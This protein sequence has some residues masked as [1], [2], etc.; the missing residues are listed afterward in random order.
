[1]SIKLRFSIVKMKYPKNRYYIITKKLISFIFD[2]LVP[3]RHISSPWNHN[4][5]FTYTCRG[6]ARPV[7][8]KM[9]HVIPKVYKNKNKK[10][11]SKIYCQLNDIIM[12]ANLDSLIKITN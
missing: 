11:L 9:N 1:M 2:T 10:E 6:H 3:L 12:I 4:F 7:I 8:I 5:T